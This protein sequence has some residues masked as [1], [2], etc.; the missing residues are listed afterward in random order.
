MGERFTAIRPCQPHFYLTLLGVH[1]HHRG[2]G[3][4]M[5]LLAESLARI[6]ALGAPAYLESSNPANLHRYE[7]VGFVALDQIAMATG[8]VVTNMSRPAAVPGP[9][10]GG[11]AR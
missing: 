5:A 2:K 6:D 1:D 7:T 11:H 10:T 4:G 3:L 9:G 8:H